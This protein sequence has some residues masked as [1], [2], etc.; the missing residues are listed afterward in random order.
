[1]D[2]A[3]AV[4]DNWRPR[5]DVDPDWP[6]AGIA[7]LVA[8]VPHSFK[9]GPFGSSLKKDCYVP[10]GYKVYGQEQVIRGDATFG[11]YYIDQENTDN[12][13]AAKLG[14]ATCWLAWSERTGR[15]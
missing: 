3:R 11:D 7:D 4:V 1:M 12:L 14:L 2:G 15:P 8:D 6:V 5:I 13:R 10:A 9:A